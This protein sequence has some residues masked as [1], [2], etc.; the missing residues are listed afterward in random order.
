MVI[1]LASA[2]LGINGSILVL[3]S[4][5]TE[6]DESVLPLLDHSST[7]LMLLQPGETWSPANL[8][9]TSTSSLAT[10]VTYQDSAKSVSTV[11]SAPIS[12]QEP[13]LFYTIDCNSEMLWESFEIPYYKMPNHMIS[14]CEA[15]KRDKQV[16]TDM[17]HIIVNEL[18]TINTIIPLKSMKIIAKKLTQKYPGTFQDVDEDG[19]VIGDGC[20]SLLLKLVDR[21]NYLN[22]PHKRKS[23]SQT[24]CPVLHKKRQ[25]NKRAGC[26]NW[27]PPVTDCIEQNTVDYKIMMN[28][29]SEDFNTLMETTYPQQRMFINNVNPPTVQQIKQEWPVLFSPR[30]IKYHFKKLTGADVDCLSQQFIEKGE[31]IIQLAKR[32]KIDASTETFTYEENILRLTANHFKEEYREIL[33][34]YEVKNKLNKN[35]VKCI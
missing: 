29:N 34:E 27:A 6:V 16:I 2:K 8:N 28:A 25:L 35:Q 9:S 26:S 11:Q 21:N 17:V 20:Q 13:T 4:D 12:L 5:G 15:G 14:H 23:D 18:R 22:R 19:V 33:Y 30:G 7:T 31:K 32:N 24:E 1:I 3:E 10:T